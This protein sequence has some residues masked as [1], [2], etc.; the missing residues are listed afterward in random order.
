MRYEIKDGEH[1]HEIWEDGEK[2]VFKNESGNW[3]AA[4]GKSSAKTD[5]VAWY[6]ETDGGSD[7]DATEPK[8]TVENGLKTEETPDSKKFS[9]E[10]GHELVIDSED[11]D[12]AAAEPRAFPVEEE[13]KLRDDGSS[14]IQKGAT[15]HSEN[16]G[17]TG[18]AGGQSGDLP[19]VPKEA[20]AYSGG[21]GNLT[22]AYLWWAYNQSDD[23]FLS[24]YGKSKKDWESDHG[25][26]LK[27]VI[28]KLQN[29]STF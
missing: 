4:H 23:V 15:V 5:A 13:V 11:K 7:E 3:Q 24:L 12:N 26:Y 27:S 9:A 2:I 16:I 19:P 29:P 17:K 21:L 8:V 18:L 1:G 14:V 10:V 22:P 25:G 28:A 6:D 20:P